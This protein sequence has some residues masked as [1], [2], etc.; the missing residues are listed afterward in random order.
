MVRKTVHFGVTLL[1]C[2]GCAATVSAQQA[3]YS[4]NRDRSNKQLQSGSPILTGAD[5]GRFVLPSLT[6]YVMGVATVGQNNNPSLFLQS[7]KRSPGT[8]YYTFKRFTEKGEPVFSQGVRLYL[9]FEDTGENRGVILQDSKHNI[10]G[11]WR[12]SKVLKYARFNAAS[13]QFGDLQTLAVKGLPRNFS[14]FGVTETSKG[15]FL[16]VFAV[17]KPGVFSDPKQGPDSAYYTS[18]GFWPFDL[19]SAGVYGALTNDFTRT[20]SLNAVVLTGLDEALFS[21]SGFTSYREGQTAYVVGGVR[22]GNFLAYTLDENKGI[23]DK[24]RYL[25]GTDE[26]LLRQPGV[27]AFPAYCKM[28]GNKEGII[29]SGEGGIC[30]YE[31]IHRSDSKGNPVFSDPVYLMQED[32]ELYGGSLVV[33]SLADWDG[34]GVT[35]MISGASSGHIFF[36]KNT[37]TNSKP[38]FQSP[39]PLK[40]G[41]R[42]IHIQPGY[43]EDIQGPGEARWGYTCPTV[44]D[45]NDDGLPDILT[46][47]SRGKFMV[48]INTG[49]KAQPRLEPEHPLYMDGMNVHGGWRVRPGAGKLNGKMAYII[50]DRDNEFHLYRQL[51]Q[52]NLEDGGKLMMSDGKYIK[53]NRRPGGQ[54]GRMKIDL[55]D[56]DGDGVKDL[57][58]GTGRSASVPNPVNG[59]PYNRAKKNEGAAVLFLKN[60]GTEA[61]P[62]FEFPK[63]MEFKGKD[64]LLGAHS[65]SP[66]ATYIGGDGK[67]LNLVVGTE[68]GTYMFYDRKDLSW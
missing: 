36:F 19:P 51:D 30:F 59:L 18:E 54:V 33:P 8:Y 52:Y 49:T 6:G 32:P 12:F 45:W 55:V 46:G 31:N 61:K 1:L 29:A 11:F 35:D 60:A 68:Y 53:A 44:I 57:L 10:W 15:K 27:N 24:K 16:F 42:E 3:T 23:F 65:C 58:V 39:V 62:V 7:D 5:I 43:R 66:A 38:A 48:F 2:L 63:M 34:D 47:D 26:V 21:F 13:G 17:G 40:A 4:I 50:L 67:S 37:G 28:P 64:I 25:V 9:P 22:M 20:E 41:G 56:W 14:T